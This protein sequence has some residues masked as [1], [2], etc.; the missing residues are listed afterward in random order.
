MSNAATNLDNGGD[1]TMK[2]TFE[3]LPDGDYLVRMQELTEKKTKNGD[4][5]LTAKFQVVKGP[6]GVEGAKNRIVFE[7]FV[8]THDNPKVVEISTGKLNKY[9]EAIGINGG[10]D[11]LSGGVGDLQ[12]YLETPFIATLGQGKPYNGKINNV[13]KAFKAR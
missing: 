5:M 4:D 9:A 8:M 10:I 13:I 11:S 12:D 1:S 6:D 3:P 2:K 7:N